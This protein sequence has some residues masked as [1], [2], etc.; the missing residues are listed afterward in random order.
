MPVNRKEVHIT[1]FVDGL[2]LR[3]L[4]TRIKIK[5]THEGQEVVIWSY[6]HGKSGRFGSYEIIRPGLGCAGIN[7]KDST[8]ELLMVAFREFFN[9]KSDFLKAAL[10]ESNPELLTPSTD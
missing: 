4:N 5:P 1:I 2:V 8:I 10:P 7:L 6:T 9:H 3:A